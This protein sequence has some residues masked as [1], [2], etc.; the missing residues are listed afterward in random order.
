VKNAK[1]IIPTKKALKY[2]SK[3]V[4]KFHREVGSSMKKPEINMVMPTPDKMIT[5]DTISFR[6]FHSEPSEK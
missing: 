6:K 3:K 4:E 5:I 1:G 2:E